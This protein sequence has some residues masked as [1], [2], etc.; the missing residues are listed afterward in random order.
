MNDRLG[1][2]LL[3]QST[4]LMDIVCS[5]PE[6]FARRYPGEPETT[7]FPTDDIEALTYADTGKRYELYVIIEALKWPSFS[8]VE[9]ISPCPTNFYRH[10]GFKTPIDFYKRLAKKYKIAAGGEKELAADQLGILKTNG[11]RNKN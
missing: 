5:H 8:F 3:T 7:N 4:S 2:S 9:V 11:T 10:L 1:N 6:F